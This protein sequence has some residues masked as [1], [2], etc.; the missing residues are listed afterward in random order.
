[1]RPIFQ[2]AP[3]F[4]EGRKPETLRALEEAARAPGVAL[5][6]FSADPDHN[7]CVAT[8]LGDAEG[9]ELASLQMAAVAVERIH[10]TAH[11]GM[12]PRLGALDVMPFI[13]FRDAGIEDADRLARV[14]GRRIAD[15]LGVPV[16]L[17]AASASDPSR[18]PLPVLRRG[19]YETLAQK[20][21]EL[22]PDFGPATPHPTAGAAVVGAR[23]PL[24]AFNVNLDSNDLALARRIAARLRESNGGL[25]GVRALGLP[26]TS[27]GYVQVS[28]NITDVRATTLI[29]VY[30]TVESL[31]ASAGVSVRDSELIGGIALD[32]VLSALNEAIQGDIGRG[33]V[34]DTHLQ[35][36]TVRNPSGL[37]LSLYQ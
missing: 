34:L 28:V 22:P 32:S 13:P 14:V 11:T 25:P 7:R 33:Q 6:D 29:A 15:E 23:P 20:M 1:M 3:N 21:R 17:Y 26:M 9:L 37:L 36:R 31:A 18:A 30:R 35:P 27:A 4:S 16:Y 12:H 24:L 19:G 10:L 5:A 2:S 8:L